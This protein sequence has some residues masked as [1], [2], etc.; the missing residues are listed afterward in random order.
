VNEH[1]AVPAFHIKNQ[2]P[3][4]TQ[5]GTGGILK[6]SQLRIMHLESDIKLKEMKLSL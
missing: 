5:M 1:H 3:V 6:D 4:P 2:S